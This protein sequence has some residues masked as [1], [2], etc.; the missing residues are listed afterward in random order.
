MSAFSPLNKAI[1]EGVL[2]NKD[3]ETGKFGSTAYYLEN[4]EGNSFVVFGTTVLDRL[5]KLVRIGEEILIE[6]TGTEPSKKTSDT[7][8]FKVYKR[9]G[10]NLPSVN[11][12]P[13]SREEKEVL[14]NN[15]E[16]MGG[17]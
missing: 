13:H 6:F 5:M 16:V 14:E 12:Q 15:D 8:I 4:S 2:V 10:G 17:E 9:D 7:K 3:E 11:D 1:L